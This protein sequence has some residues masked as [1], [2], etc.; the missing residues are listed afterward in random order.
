M[1]CLCALDVC[2]DW[3]SG[4]GRGKK[5]RKGGGVPGCRGGNAR[6]AGSGV[7]DFEV[8]C[9]SGGDRRVGCRTQDSGSPINTSARIRF[10]GLLGCI[11]PP[12]IDPH[13]SQ[14]PHTVLFK[15]ST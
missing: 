2:T 5:E 4:G 1:M 7:S 15:D 3:A 12:Q 10:R 14:D 13:F 11:T 9:G 6:G 8:F